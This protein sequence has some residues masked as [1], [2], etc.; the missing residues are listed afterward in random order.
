[1]KTPIYPTFKPDKPSW[2]HP[3]QL[4]YRKTFG[5]CYT[6][7]GSRE[8]SWG[9]W[10]HWP[11]SPFD[12]QLSAVE[13]V[14]R[15][16]GEGHEIRTPDNQFVFV[17]PSSELQYRIIDVVFNGESPWKIGM[18]NV[19]KQRTFNSKDDSTVVP[20]SRLRVR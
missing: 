9:G 2:H 5:V 12:S 10:Q 6:P 11:I 7:D 1:M 20:R 4:Q 13:F 15:F 3:W 16:F 14:N 19:F 17:F 8:Q 18:T